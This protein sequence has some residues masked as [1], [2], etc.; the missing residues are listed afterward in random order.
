M[1]ARTRGQ[2]GDRSHPAAR[3]GGRFHG[4]AGVA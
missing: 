4:E 1:L 3:D 2:R